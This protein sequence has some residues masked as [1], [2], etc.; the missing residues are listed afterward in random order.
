MRGTFN[1]YIKR[2]APFLVLFLCLQS[3]LRFALVLRELNN[4]NSHPDRI[5]WLVVRGLGSD[6]LT[7]AFLGLPVVAYLLF[8]PARKWG[9]AADRRITGALFFLT[10]YLLLFDAAAEWFFWDEFSTRFNFIA[11]DYLVY[12]HE[13]IGNIRESYPVGWLLAL[14]GAAAGMLTLAARPFLA[15]P[16]QGPRLRRRF[17]ATLGFAALAVAVYGA[18]PSA[19]GELHKNA[20][21]SELAKNG[22]YTLFAAFWEN[23]LDYASFYPTLPQAE[24]DT[25]LRALLAGNDRVMTAP[26]GSLRATHTIRKPGAEKR[27]NVVITVM[28]SLSGSYMGTFGNTEGLTPNLDGLTK[29]SLF[30]SRLYATGTRTVRGLEAI[31][32]GIPPGPGNSIMRRPGNENLSSVGFLFKDRGYDTKFI[33]GGYGYFDNMNYF[34]AKNGFAT[35]DRADL[36]ARETSFANVWGVADEDLF[37]RVLAEGDKSHAAGKP[38]MDVVMTTSNHRPF[39]YP[40]G[41]IDIPSGQ[42]R[43]GGVKYADYAVGKFLADARKKPWF[44]NTLFVF[45]ADHTAGSAG[46]TALDAEKYHI[47]AM[48]YAP[49]LVKPRTIG[50]ITSQIDLVPTLLGLMNF[51]YASNFYG[52]DALAAPPGRAFI[53][54]YQYL[55]YLTPQGLTLLKPGKVSRI[56]PWQQW[57]DATKDAVAYYQSTADWR[58]NFKRVETR[59]K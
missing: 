36:S 2:L 56:P 22:I 14:I 59:V 13:V 19:S 15:R 30:F 7:F 40:D 5:L 41:R 57:D 32:L 58:D 12:T 49:K 8:L 6:V 34:F 43:I 21:M 45:V 46:K 10:A 23:E 47:P 1:L 4:F 11:V 39:T 33:Y 16:P 25:R 27:W 55:G 17:S 42:G 28:E 44:D 18:A 54:N 31:A 51:S 20:Y 9:A 38:F 37:G 35:V 53:G 48:I 24:V 52:K 26:P 3:L 29:E 50:T